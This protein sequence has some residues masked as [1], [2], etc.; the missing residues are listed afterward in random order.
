MF[1]SFYFPYDV[2]RTFDH[3]ILQ[4]DILAGRLFVI[5]VMSGSLY[6][7]HRKFVNE[8]FQTMKKSPKDVAKYVNEQV[9]ATARETGDAD[10]KSKKDFQQDLQFLNQGESHARAHGHL[11]FY[12]LYR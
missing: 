6:M 2:T 12:I 7:I 5:N 9:E 10:D 4:L 8:E 1:V 3:F 11:I